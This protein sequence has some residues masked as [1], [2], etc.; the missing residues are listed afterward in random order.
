MVAP[1]PTAGACSRRMRRSRLAANSGRGCT[2]TTGS[3]RAASGS[4]SIA[5]RL[6][7][8]ATKR[9]PGPDE[10]G[11]GRVQASAEVVGDLLHGQTIEVPQRQGS[12]LGCRQARQGIVSRRDVELFIPGVVA[13]VA[14]MPDDG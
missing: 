4:F 10:E 9:G 11:L 3:R 1:L 7:I 14:L 5:L 6:L 8:D 2:G 12:A 13:V